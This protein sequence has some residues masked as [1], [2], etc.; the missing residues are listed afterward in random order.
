MSLS[1]ALLRAIGRPPA[2]L[3]GFL[4]LLAVLFA[5]AW[6]AGRAAGPVAPDT[7]RA[8]SV[9]HGHGGP[10]GTAGMTGTTGM[11]GMGGMG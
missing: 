4:L 7:H 6:T 1:P 10:H 3:A 9:G 5:A 11:T 8:P 2:A